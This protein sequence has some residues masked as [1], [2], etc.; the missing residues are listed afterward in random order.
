M[1]DFSHEWRDIHEVLSGFKLF[2]SRVVVPGGSKSLIAA[3]ID[4]PLTRLGWREREFATA[5][6]VD[7]ET[8]ESPTHKVDCFSTWSFQ[9]RGFVRQEL[10]LQPE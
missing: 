7:E 8:L 6:R 1:K 3:A 5:I 9:F 2:K 10:H 4:E